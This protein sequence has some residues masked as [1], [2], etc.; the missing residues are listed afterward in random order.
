MKHAAI[1]GGAAVASRLVGFIMLPFYAHI[2]RG[3]G[4][5]VI[6]M[7]DVGIGFLLSLLVYGMQGVTIRLYHDEKDPARKPWVVSTGVILMGAVTAVL[8]VPMIIFSKPLAG[9][10]IDDVSLYRLVILALLSFN[11][12]MIGSAAST[13]LLLRSRSAQMAALSLLRLILGLSLNIYLILIKGMGLDGYFISAL[14]VNVLSCVVFVAICFRGCGRKYDPDTARKFQRLVLPLVPGSL[15]SW[16]GR[17][18]ER[19]LVK[20]LINL[21]SVGILEMAYKFPILISMIV[22]TPFMQ[23]W[24]TRRFE[25]ADEPG[26]PQ[27]IARMFTY[28]TFILIWFGLIMAVVIKPVLQVLTPPEFH[29]AYRIARIEIVTL[30]FQGAQFHLV[31]GLAYAKDMAL[32]SKLRTGAAAAKVLLSWFFIANWGIYGAA[33]S[34][35][36]MGAVAMMMDFH[37]SQ[38]RYHLPLEYPT[39]GICAATAGGLFLWLVHWDVTATAAFTWVDSQVLPW[40]QGGLEHTFLGTW[41]DGKVML[42]LTERSA[43]I[44]EILLKGPLAAAYIVVLPAIHGPTRTKWLARVRRSPA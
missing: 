19:V 18:A 27:T 39:L 32:V 36:V 33:F 12:E 43:P 28:F 5:A 14:A 31:F 2:L 20:G 16:V 42:A 44:A 11:L 35:A 22:V 34:A 38:K 26:A 41:K 17:Q 13:W 1:Y 3:H 7:L 15:A 23:A 6:G 40:L 9:L 4:Y 37:F 30:I 10:L 21:N 24:D 8:S 25:I 29:L